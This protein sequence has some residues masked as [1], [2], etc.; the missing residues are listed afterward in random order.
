MRSKRR[1]PLV[2]TE[3]F[4]GDDRDFCEQWSVSHGVFREQFL[5][6]VHAKT[7][8]SENGIFLRAVDHTHTHTY[9]P[10]HLN[11]HHDSC[12]V[13]HLGLIVCETTSALSP[14]HLL[15]FR[16]HN[17]RQ[18][19]NPRSEFRKKATREKS[20]LRCGYCAHDDT[21]RTTIELPLK[22]RRQDSRR[23][24][25]PPRRSNHFL[26]A[27]ATSAR[28]MTDRLRRIDL[29][30]TCVTVNQNWVRA[31]CSTAVNEYL[32]WT[33]QFVVMTFSILIKNDSVFR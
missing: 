11:H 15:F 16:L 12:A 27:L 24:L 10:V 14:S 6:S 4:P 22:V 23:V 8:I 1:Q 19:E 3:I 5:R 9:I 28:Q 32:F 7:C 2:N 25:R 13:A 20:A 30:Y 33:C 18:P 31:F 29:L 21:N 17:P 26:N